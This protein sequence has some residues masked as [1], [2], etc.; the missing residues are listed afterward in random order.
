MGINPS[1]AGGSTSTNLEGY[2]TRGSLGSRASRAFSNSTAASALALSFASRATSSSSSGDGI[3]EVAALSL[4][5]L[6]ASNASFLL[7]SVTSC[8]CTSR[9]AWTLFFFASSASFFAS[10]IMPSSPK[11]SASAIPAASSVSCDFA[12]ASCLFKIDSTISSNSI[13]ACIL[14]STVSFDKS[15][16]FFS[17]VSCAVYSSISF[18]LA[19]LSS[20]RDAKS[21]VMAFCSSFAA[22]IFCLASSTAGETVPTG[23]SS[24]ILSA[25]FSSFAASVA[26]SSEGIVVSSVGSGVVASSGSSAGTVSSA[27]ASGA[28]VLSGVGVVS[29]PP[30]LSTGGEVGASASRST[31]SSTPG[32]SSCNALL[33]LLRSRLPGPTE[34][35]EGAAGAV[36]GEDPNT[37]P[38]HF[39]LVFKA[40]PFPWNSPSLTRRMNSFATPPMTT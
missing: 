14:A 17:A 33:A 35:G 30:K 12:I 31:T 22:A 38:H 19:S 9:A 18:F 27:S 26:V 4:P 2:V 11:P 23:K 36:E 6:N 3:V 5:V 16:A 15:P 10:S 32:S 21:A 29:V 7:S 37:L 1:G 20:R 40:V 25:N 24:A 13:S 34:A 39:S 28:G 8:L